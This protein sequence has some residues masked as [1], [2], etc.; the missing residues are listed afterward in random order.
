MVIGVTGGVGAG[1]STVLEILKREYHARIIMAD[2]VAR[3]LMRKGGA[4]YAPV[5]SAFGEEILDAEGEI[6]RKKLAAI[7]FE[8]EEKRSLLNSLVHPKVKEEIL[9]LIN[10]YYAED[11]SCLIVIEAALLIEAGYKDILDSLWFVYVEKEIRI[12]RLMR[13]RGYT[14]DKALSIMASQLSD[15]EFRSH[16]D[17]I[18]DNSGTLAETAAQVAI[19]FANPAK[20]LSEK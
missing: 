18:I 6:D 7:V 15:E 1:K 2:D 10:G 17:F 3:D 5:L 11:A 13:D 8:D 9:S 20:Y 19:F 14:R 12:G 16:A 4:S